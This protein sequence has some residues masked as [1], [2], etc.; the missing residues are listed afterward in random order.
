MSVKAAS[1]GELVTVSDNDVICLEE[2]VFA[3]ENPNKDYGSAYSINV[4]QSVSL[5][6]LRQSMSEGAKRVA[7]SKN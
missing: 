1:Q 6:V 4:N 2:S 7:R 3:E 5:P